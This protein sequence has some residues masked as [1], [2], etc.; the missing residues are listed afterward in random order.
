MLLFFFLDPP[1]GA[2]NSPTLGA[3][4]TTIIR[5][6]K[7]EANGEIGFDTVEPMFV[8]EPDGAS[9]EVRLRLTRLG[10]SGQ[11]TITWSMEGTGPN[12]GQVT[13]ND[14]GPTSG[15]VIMGAGMVAELI[16]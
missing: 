16:V 6:T 1:N 14:T 7:N 9:S 10:T 12:K 8:D 13:V 15:T 5:V 4:D 2:F 11:A 3:R